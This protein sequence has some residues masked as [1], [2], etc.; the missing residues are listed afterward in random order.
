MQWPSTEHTSR[1][2]STTHMLDSLP[3]PVNGWTLLAVPF[4]SD[5]HPALSLTFTT[6]MTPFQLPTIMFSVS[7]QLMSVIPMHVV[8]I[9]S[10]MR[11]W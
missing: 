9:S 11:N 5:S 10:S 3:K 8:A 1:P 6:R 4:S 2:E 7:S